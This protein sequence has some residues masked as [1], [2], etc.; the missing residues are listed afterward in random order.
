MKKICMILVLCL[1]MM[2]AYGQADSKDTRIMVIKA[3]GVDEDIGGYLIP[4]SEYSANTLIVGK[5]QLDEVTG[6]LVGQ[7]EFHMT[8]YDKDGKKVYSMMGRFKNAPVQL[9]PG[10]PCFVRNVVWT[11]VWLVM[12]M[13][14]IKTTVVDESVLANFPYRNENITLPDTKGKYEEKLVGMM[15]SPLGEIAVGEPWGGWAFAGVVLPTGK[16]FG[17]ITWLTKYVEN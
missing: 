13:G 7:A 15:V 12:G 16:T 9:L 5:I 3:I 14:R 4:D 8:I 10:W 11:N 17:G 6:Q 2:V 1:A